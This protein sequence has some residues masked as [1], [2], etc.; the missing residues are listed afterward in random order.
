MANASVTIIVPIF[1]SDKFLEE[2]LQS[3]QN[4]SY[5]NIQVLL[6][7]DASSDSSPKIIKKYID[8]DPRFQAFKN[9]FNR[10]VSYSTNV[11][12]S[13]A[14]GEYITFHDHDDIMFSTKIATCVDILEKHTSFDGVISVAE[15]IS[16]NGESLGITSLLPDYITT[17]PYFV[18]AFERSYIPTW[19]M[20]LR[21]ELLKDLRFDNE[22][23]IGNQ[24]ADLFLRLLY[25]RP[26]FF[27][28][29]SP[30][31]KFRQVSGSLSKKSSSSVE[32]Y[33]KHKD[34]DIRELYKEAGYCESIINYALARVNLWRE[35]SALALDYI[36]AAHQGIDEIPLEEQ[37]GVIFIHATCLYLNKLYVPCL[38]VLSNLKNGSY[39]AE[40][41]N[42][43]GVCW[44]LVGNLSKAKN[45]FEGALSIMSEY[46]DPKNNL[47][48]F[49][50][51]QSETVWQYTRF[52]LRNLYKILNICPQWSCK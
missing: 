26:R 11:G 22:N 38:E 25:L 43:Q 5:K 49:I 21:S 48:N 44:A 30:Q 8:S 19:A 33:R 15:Y 52:P 2:T 20:F 9:D 51:P 12:L 50:S 45:S 32:I 16:E 23:K 7:D 29:S 27:Y 4:Q 41:L 36:Q 39:Q 34:I 24:D 18:R 31:N 40:V 17:N 13:N 10:G 14:N 42:N 6:I 37:D 46:K 1:N 47:K 35:D 28:L 3:I